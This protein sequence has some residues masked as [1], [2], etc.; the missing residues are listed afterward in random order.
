MDAH[1]ASLLERLPAPQAAVLGCTHYPLLQD[2]FRAALPPDTRLVSQPDIVA[3]S[4]ADYLE[5][6]PRFAAR[7]DTRYLTSGNPAEITRQAER[8]T[9]HSLPF[10]AA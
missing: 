9:G 6:H 7:G 3:D 1:V 10:A 8:F 4:L 2:R 5:R